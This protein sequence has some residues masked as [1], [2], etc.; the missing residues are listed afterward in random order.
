MSFGLCN[1]PATFE[2]LMDRVLCG[3]RWSRCLVYLDD[4]ISFGK[5]IP[6]ALARLEEV[7]S[8]LSDFGLQLKARKCTFMQ[9]E[10]GFLGHIVGRTGLACD[11]EKLSA[12]QNWH[13]PNRVKAVRQ[14]IGFVGYYRRFVK[15]IAELAEL[16]VSLTRKGSPFVWTGQQQTAFDALKDCL[17]SAPILGF[18]TEEGRF[19]L[20]TDA[21]LFAVGG[22]LNQIQ[23]EEEVVIAYASCSFRI[24]Q[25]RYCTTRR[26]MLAAVVMCTHFRSY[27]R[28]S[29]FTL[30]T[31]HSSLRWLHKFKNEDGMLAR[32]YL[33][34]GQFS[35]TFEYRP[36]SQHAD[37]DG[38]SRQCGQCRRPDC[39][40][41]AADLPATDVETQ[42][43][44][45]D[46][47]FASSEMGDSM[48]ADL[49][50]ELSGETWVAS[51]LLEELTADL[52]TAGSDIDLIGSVPPW[53]ACAGLS[54]ELRC[55][56][57]QVGN[58][59]VDT[60]GRLW[61]HRETPSKASS[62][63]VAPIRER[64]DLIRR[65]HDSLFA[66]HL[67]VTRTVFRLQN[68]VYWPGIRGD[69]RTYIASCTI[70]LARKSPCPRRTPWVTSRWDID[71]IAWPWIC[72]TCRLLLLGEI[73]TFWSWWTV[74]LD[75]QR[76]A[77][78][79]TKL[80]SQWQMRSLARLYVTSGCR[81]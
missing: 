43:V 17:L 33:L 42:S 2:R 54:P 63:L 71:G 19:V 13:E 31:D 81:W 68:R 22:V 8:R 12:V 1:A 47:P 62:K 55:W 36:G 79:L 73:D 38:M 60:E 4:V 28:G 24:S 48:D 30:R 69:V 7:L 20:D 51:A 40:V 61:R 67:G 6:E 52:P 76:H 58:L 32:W 78:Y 27:L 74:S 15:K 65:F 14:F 29:Q 57:L 50:P 34:L 11:P 10:V 21:S 49:L 18:P 45:M 66:G 26:E 72:W 70:C 39:P 59:S 56:R 23:N 64:Q 75:G 77:R 53:S 35:V 5:S 46:Q 9:T 44:L 37:A 3:M 80:H 16:L 41:S 25:R